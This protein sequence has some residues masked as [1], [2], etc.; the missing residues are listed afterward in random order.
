[1]LQNLSGLCGSGCKCSNTRV[2]FLC[3]LYGEREGHRG[4]N[5]FSNGI[6][7]GI[8]SRMINSKADHNTLLIQSMV[9]QRASAEDLFSQGSVSGGARGDHCIGSSL[10]SGS[11]RRVCSSR[12]TLSRDCRCVMA[13]DE[14]DRVG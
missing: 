7:V 10:A 6:V 14:R 3:V 12:P 4:T 13:Q 8:A 11:N 9:A 5:V 2:G 1:M